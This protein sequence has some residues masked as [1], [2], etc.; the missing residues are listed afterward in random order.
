MGAVALFQNIHWGPINT[1]TLPEQCRSGYQLY[2]SGLSRETEPLGCL[3]VCIWKE[4][5][6]EEL[7]PVIMEADKAQDPQA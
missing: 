7:G 4:I 5:C 2:C 1:G 6:Y 3:Y